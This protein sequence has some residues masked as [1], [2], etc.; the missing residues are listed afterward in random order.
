VIT[1][2][3]C[4]YEASVLVTPE[5][6]HRAGAAPHTGA[7]HAP[8]HRLGLRPAPLGGRAPAPPGG[9]AC[10]GG[11]APAPP[12]GQG[13]AP[14]VSLG[15]APPTA[16]GRIGAVRVFTLTATLIRPLAG[17]LGRAWLLG[18]LPGPCLAG[19]AVRPYV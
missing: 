4:K 12:G 18:W 10:A 1:S 8:R 7:G 16:K 14:S 13:R 17:L 5:V 6:L 9:Y 11:D 15:A 3:Q 2:H 19:W